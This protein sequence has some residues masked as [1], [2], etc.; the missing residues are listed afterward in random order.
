VQP[1]THGFGDGGLSFTAE[2]GFH[3]GEMLRSLHFTKSKE[4]CGFDFYS[5]VI[6]F[7]E[8]CFGFSAPQPGV[9]SESRG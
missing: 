6:Y 5:T 8:S 2:C 4:H 1:I 7:G 9:P 3:E